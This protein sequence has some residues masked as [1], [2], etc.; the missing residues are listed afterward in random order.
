M[1]HA[2]F[3]SYV[4][5]YAY[6]FAKIILGLLLHPYQ[7]LFSM[8]HNRFARLL[9]ISPGAIFLVLTL[10]W[11]LLFRPL[12]LHFFS[13]TC[14]LMVIK[15]SALFFCLFWQ[16]SLLYLFFKFSRALTASSPKKGKSL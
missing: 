14:L 2:S 16:I 1:S 8:I 7:T 10:L 4:T 3:F 11:R 9:V 5:G 6:I 15:T 12:I 13:A